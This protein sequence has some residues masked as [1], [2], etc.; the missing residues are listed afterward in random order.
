MGLLPDLSD[1]VEWSHEVQPEEAWRPAVEVVA[2]RHGLGGRELRHQASG[3]D[4]VFRAGRGHVVKLTP[5]RDRWQHEVERAVLAHVDGALPVATPP[6]EA[7]G[8]LEGWGYVVMGFVDGA[9]IGDVWGGLD[10]A[11]REGLAEDIGRLARALHELPLDGLDAV[12]PTEWGAWIAAQQDGAVAL[13]R[14]RGAPEAMLEAVA[15]YLASVDLAPSGADERVASR[16]PSLMHTELIGEHVLVAER[17]GRWRAVGLIDLADAMVGEPLYELTAPAEFLFRRDTACLRAALRGYGVAEA[18]IDEELG[19]RLFGLH[20]CHRYASL[21]RM[22]TFLGEPAPAT[23]D[24]VRRAL[25][26]L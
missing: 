6:L 1:V 4:V 3:T 9:A 16:G 18:A 10:A 22:V 11:H 12:P 7:S 20:L 24:E 13:H 5:P 17:G 25:Y 23:L 15:A 8:E 2:R 19:R 14:R 21:A 26:P